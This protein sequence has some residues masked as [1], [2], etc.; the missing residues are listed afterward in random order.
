[1]SA[2]QEFRGTVHGFN[3]ERHGR[4]GAGG[5]GKVVK[6][7]ILLQTNEIAI[8]TTGCTEPG[9][10]VAG[11][12]KYSVNNNVRGQYG[13]YFVFYRTALKDVSCIVKMSPEVLCVN[14]CV[15]PSASGNGN[16]LSQKRKRAC[17]RTA[18]TLGAF[19]WICQ[20]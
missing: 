14:T 7:W 15:G 5:R 2:C 4:I 20:P 12:G 16:R 3:I 1:M 19:C 11:Y 8:A 18:C 13:I 17:S 10:T 9:M 6:E